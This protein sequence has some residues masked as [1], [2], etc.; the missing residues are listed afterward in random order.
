VPGSAAALIPTGQSPAWAQG[1]PGGPLRMLSDLGSF[2]GVASPPNQ[3]HASSLS[4]ATNPAI[5]ATPATALAPSTIASG[6]NTFALTVTGTN[7]TPQSVVLHQ[8]YPAD[9]RIRPATS[10]TVAAALAADRRHLS[11]D[12]R[13]R[14]RG[15]DRQRA[16]AMTY[17]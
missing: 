16:P 8:R 15:R 17:T 14:R 2:T 10:L 3:Q 13:D 5:S 1:D 11:G 4:P 7:F 9:D 6:V 12:A